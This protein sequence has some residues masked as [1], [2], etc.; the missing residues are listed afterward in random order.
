MTGRLIISFGNKN[1]SSHSKRMMSR[2]E[3]KVWRKQPGDAA[4]VLL[5]QLQYGVRTVS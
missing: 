4:R 1:E 2:G 3:E 5:D